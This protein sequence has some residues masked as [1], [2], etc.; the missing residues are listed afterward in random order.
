MPTNSDITQTSTGSVTLSPIAQ[1]VAVGVADDSPIASA[2]GIFT[3]AP[4]PTSGGNDTLIIDSGTDVSV[5]IGGAGGTDDSID[6]VTGAGTGGNDTITVVTV[7]N[8]GAGPAPLTASVVSFIDDGVDGGV[9][10]SPSSGGNDTITLDDG[11]A[12]GPGD[13]ISGNDSFIPLEPG[14]GTVIEV[15][16]GSNGAFGGVVLGSGGGAEGGDPVSADIREAPIIIVDRPIDNGGGNP[17]IGAPLPP[18]LDPDD[19]LDAGLGTVEISL[20]PAALVPAAADVPP[21]VLDNGLTMIAQA[22]PAGGSDDSL[23]ILATSA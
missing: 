6:V 2:D 4:V 22:A 20:P 1:A 12:S 11:P 14:D 10:G 23:A 17:L 19:L 16:N 5:T 9:G 13:V 7:G 3:V 21:P 18:V 15:L 8:N